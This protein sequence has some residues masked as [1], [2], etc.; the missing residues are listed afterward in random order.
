MSFLPTLWSHT[1]TC[2]SYSLCFAVLKKDWEIYSVTKELKKERE[3]KAKG[4]QGKSMDKKVEKKYST[5]PK[6]ET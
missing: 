1:E 6:S 2:C 4:G 3:L 5:I